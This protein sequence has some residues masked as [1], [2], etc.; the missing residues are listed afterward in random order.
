MVDKNSEDYKRS[1]TPPAFNHIYFTDD[2][3]S[4]LLELRKAFEQLK[5]NGLVKF[6]NE[7]K[8]RAL[9]EAYSKIKLEQGNRK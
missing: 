3:I 6:K 4:S 8:R 1:L 2:E 5:D 9:D 7:R